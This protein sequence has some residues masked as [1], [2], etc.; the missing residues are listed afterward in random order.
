MVGLEMLSVQ[1]ILFKVDESHFA[2][3]LIYQ[4]SSVWVFVREISLAYLIKVFIA[5]CRVV[6]SALQA[7]NYNA[8]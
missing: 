8:K 5:F 7:V 6:I 1:K 4:G 3:G 2:N